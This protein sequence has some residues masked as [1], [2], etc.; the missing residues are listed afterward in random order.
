MKKKSEVLF[1]MPRSKGRS[2]CNCSGGKILLGIFMGLLV[3]PSLI[4]LLCTM[5]KNDKEAY[6]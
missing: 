5:A 2:C 3:I 6:Y 4:A 1:N